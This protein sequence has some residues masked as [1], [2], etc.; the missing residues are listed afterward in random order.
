[1]GN[2]SGQRG[3]YWDGAGSTPK[4][5]KGFGFDITNPNARPS[6]TSI[7]DVPGNEIFTGAVLALPRAGMLRKES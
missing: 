2:I 5:R 3:R 6:N 7:S 1:M 4:S